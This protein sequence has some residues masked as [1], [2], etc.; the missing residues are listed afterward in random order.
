MPIPKRQNFRNIDKVQSSRISKGMNDLA[1]MHSRVVGGSGSDWRAKGD[2][3]SDMFLFEGKDKA[4][5]SKQRTVYRAI[6]DK[7]A[8][9]ALYEGGKIPVYAIG[10]GDGEDFMIL[11]DIDFYS[12]VDR[13]LSAEKELKALK[14][15]TE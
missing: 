10:F 11:K 12:I 13:M 14:G 8:E 5:K 3:Y 4:T 9:E 15:E 7:I 2:V 1:G 6:F